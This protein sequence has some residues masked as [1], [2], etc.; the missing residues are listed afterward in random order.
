M[1]P[2]VALVSLAVALAGGCTAAGPAVSERITVDGRALVYQSAPIQEDA[3]IV[4]VWTARPG[5]PP[6]S[7]EEQAL[8]MKGARRAMAR[9]CGAETMPRIVESSPQGTRQAAALVTF[10]CEKGPRPPPQRKPPQDMRL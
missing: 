5:F 6:N 7:M 2:R 3:H 9:I 4:K 10:R 1:D 8:R